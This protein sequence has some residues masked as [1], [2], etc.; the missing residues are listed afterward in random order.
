M[1][2][3]HCLWSPMNL[4]CSE[5]LWAP[6]GTQQLAG[7]KMQPGPRLAQHDN[8]CQGH[9]CWP[10]LTPWIQHRTQSWLYCGYIQMSKAVNHSKGVQRQLI[11]GPTSCV[12]MELVN[13]AVGQ[14]TM[15]W[16]TIWSFLAELW[17]ITRFYETVINRLMIPSGKRLHNYGKSQSFNG[18]IHYFY[19]HFQ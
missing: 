2:P 13:L 19:G 5:M 4:Y 14:V 10:N 17:T 18:K 9:L 7:P 3:I 8:L 6:V 15:G 12:L 16:G 11:S 1:A